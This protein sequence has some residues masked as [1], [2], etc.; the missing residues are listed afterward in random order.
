MAAGLTSSTSPYHLVSMHKQTNRRHQ[1]AEE[2]ERHNL[3]LLY[4]V[5][6]SL[7]L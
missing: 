3:P 6:A 2:Y 1:Q 4:A 7:L 5:N